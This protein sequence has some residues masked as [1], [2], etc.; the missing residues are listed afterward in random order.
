MPR[1]LHLASRF[2]AALTLALSLQGCSQIMQELG[3][4]PN[5]YTP[6]LTPFSGY[7]LPVASTL[8]E[9]KDRDRRREAERLEREAKRLEQQRQ[10]TAHKQEN[11]KWRLPKQ[12]S[13]D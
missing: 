4:E 10:K 7:A 5:E 6:Y 2:F 8:E 12:E 1:I 3:L 9:A 13:G 11:R